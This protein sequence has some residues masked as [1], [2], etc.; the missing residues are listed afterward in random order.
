MMISVYFSHYCLLAVQNV[1]VVYYVKLLIS[2]KRSIV[3]IEGN[4]KW[5]EF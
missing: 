1:G 2:Y 5:N 4:S 3:L